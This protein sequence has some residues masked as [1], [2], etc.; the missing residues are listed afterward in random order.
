MPNEL[1]KL[2]VAFRQ[3]A[4]AIQLFFEDR[5]PVSVYTLAGNAWEIFDSLCRHQD[6]DG[7]SMHVDKQLSTGISLRQVV[8]VYRNFFKHADRDPGDTIKFSDEWNEHLLFFAAS[9]SFLLD[10]TRLVE[11]AIFHTWYFAVDEER[12]PSGIREEIISTVRA[13]LPKIRGVSRSEQ[14]AMGKELLDSS[15]FGS[16]IGDQWSDVTEFNRWII[17]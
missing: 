17:R 5:D 9:D 2:D 3:V 4:V 14:K 8:N 12:I 7:W 1:T 16:L 15:K 10:E 6:L 11:C 13:E